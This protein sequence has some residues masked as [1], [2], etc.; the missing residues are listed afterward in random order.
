MFDLYK[1]KQCLRCKNEFKS[2]SMIHGDDV[3]ST[4]ERMNS[5]TFWLP[6]LQNVQCPIPKTIM[7]NADIDL[8]PMVDGVEVEGT[9]RF[10]NELNNAA[11]ILGFPV[12]L[13]TEMLS[14]KHDWI[15]SCFIENEKQ[16]PS[17]IVNLLEMSAVVTIDRFK[18]CNFFAIRKMIETEKAFT[19][20]NG[21]PITKEIRVFIRNGKIECQH[22][23]WPKDVF[24]KIDDTLIKKVQEL[25]DDDKDIINKYGN[26]LA[27]IF[28]GWWSVDFLKSKKGDWY[29]TDMAIGESSWHDEKCINKI[30]EHLI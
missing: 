20:F 23:Y 25:N 30:K 17:H 6:K 13:R 4:C 1:M 16:F 10:F 26:Y 29:C 19:Y 5:I 12:F 14:N 11:N 2:N 8:G 9:D 21:M 28:H 7:I 27:K 22:P 24:E 18:D 15:N 3:C